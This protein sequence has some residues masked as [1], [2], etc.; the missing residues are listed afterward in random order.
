MLSTVRSAIYLGAAIAIW[1]GEDLVLSRA[2]G[3]GVAQT[4]AVTIYF[5]CLLLVAVRLVMGAYQ[6][7]GEAAF[8]WTRAA[9][10]APVLVVLV[11]SFASLPIFVI[12]LVVGAIF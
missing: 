6:R 5:V 3:F 7:T 2:F 4:A 10:M 9:P 11:G 1:F 8:P 12:V